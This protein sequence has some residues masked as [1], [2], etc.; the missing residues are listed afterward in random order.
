MPWAV[1]LEC[2]GISASRNFISVPSVCSGM[3]RH[4]CSDILS[5]FSIFF[6]NKGVAL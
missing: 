5:L 1:Y 4:D 2:V 3:S 6:Y